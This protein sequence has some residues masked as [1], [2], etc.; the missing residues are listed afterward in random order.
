MVYQEF[1]M[2]FFSKIKSC[3]KLPHSLFD[4]NQLS[5][6]KDFH[7][8]LKNQP[9][10]CCGGVLSRNY[11]CTCYSE[12]AFQSQFSGEIGWVLKKGDEATQDR[13]ADAQLNLLCFSP[14]FRGCYC[15]RGMLPCTTIMM[16]KTTVRSKISKKKK[17]KK[18]ASE[19]KCQK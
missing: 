4:K 13:A 19:L 17:K 10:N 14:T 18:K 8:I 1:A 5:K 6:K 12:D 9:Q 3:R 2:R 7:F 16:P 11:V 15:S